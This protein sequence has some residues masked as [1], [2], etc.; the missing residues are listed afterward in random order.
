MNIQE[1]LEMDLVDLG[2]V[3]S[4]IAGVDGLV[5]GYAI[6][7]LTVFCAPTAGGKSIITINSACV[8]SEDS[9]VLYV[10]C[11]NSL[12]D[13]Q[14]RI[15]K[16]IEKYN[17]DPQAMLFEYQNLDN[18]SI[19]FEELEQLIVDSCC[20]AVFVDSIDFIDVSANT[21]AESYNNYG[22]VAKKLRNI[23]RKYNVAIITTAQVN[24][25]GYDKKFKDISVAFLA[26]SIK[27]ARQAH[28]VW[29]ISRKDNW[30]I[31][32]LKHRGELKADQEAFCLATP[33]QDLDITKIW[34]S[35]E[36]GIP[37][38]LYKRLQNEK[39]TS[40]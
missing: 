24:R 27:I 30:A 21:G 8:M 11:E 23:A 16:I 22:L 25:D 17:L 38:D 19:G 9:S 20:E 12:A 3:E 29:Y 13:D 26:D 40:N 7:E 15:A 5:G 28:D 32:L 18:N 10:S 37:E 1:L 35:S 4:K 14:K 36:L 6:G 33:N 2:S 39:R 34:G 31:K